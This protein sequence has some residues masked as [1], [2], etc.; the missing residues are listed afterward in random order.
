MYNVG[1]FLLSSLC[2]LF[3]LDFSTNIVVIFSKLGTIGG[4]DVAR[5]GFFEV[6]NK[7]DRSEILLIDYVSFIYKE[8]PRQTD[9]SFNILVLKVE[10]ML[11]DINADDGNVG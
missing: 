4:F 8:E 10:G 2:H 3:V 7:P 1:L 5:L 11:P 6:N 9:V